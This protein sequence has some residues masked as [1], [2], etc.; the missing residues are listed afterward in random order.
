[1]AAAR[2]WLDEAAA[3]EP[4]I[5]LLRGDGGIGKS[6]LLAHLLATAREGA[7]LGLCGFCLQGARLAY[8]PL[9]SAL[10][11]LRADG[12]VLPGVP[13]SLANLFADGR[14][15][16]AG[17]SVS[18]DET[19]AAADRRHLNLVVAAAQAMLDAA[20]E[21]PLI[22]AIEDLHWADDSTLGFLELLA[23]VATQKST[24]TPV[25][26]A[27]ILTSRPTREGETAWRLTQRLKR[28]VICRD[29]E[30]TGL[31]ELEINQIVTEL[32]K[33]RPS[34]RLLHSVSEASSGNPLL[35]RSLLDR[36]IADGTIGVEKGLL[37][38]PDL[39]LPAVALDLDAELGSRLE[40]TDDR[41]AD[42]LGWAAILGDGQ[43]LTTLQTISGCD[44][45]EFDRRMGLAGSLRLLYEEGEIYRFD[46]PE[47]RE[48]L[49][50]RLPRPPA[51]PPAPGGSPVPRGRVR[52]RRPGPRCPDRLSPVAGR[53]GR[54]GNRARPPGSQRRRPLIRP[55]GLVRRRHLST[56][57]A[58]SADGSDR[59]RPCPARA[60]RRRPLP[61]PR[62]PPGRGP[63]GSGPS[64]PARAAGDEAAWGR[65]VLALTKSRV[66]GGSWLGAA[67]D[68]E[69]L[70]EFLRASSE[71]AADLRARAYSLLSDAHFAQFDFPAGFE[72]ATRA[73]EA[74]SGVD[75]HEVAAEVELAL[76][77]QHLA[78][79]HLHEAEQH[80]L[81]CQ[82]HAS[83]LADPWASSWAASRLPLVRWCQGDLA[84]AEREAT[85][86]AELA[87][88]HFDWAEAS[89]ATAC[90]VNVA[91]AQG[92]LADAE[93]LG[94]LAVQQY[95]RSDYLWT[96]LVVAPA[97]IAGRAFRG[98]AGRASEAIEMLSGAGVDTEA[99]RLA[100]AALAGQLE[101]PGAG[102]RAGPISA[103]PSPRAPYNLFDLAT[104]ALQVEVVRGHRRS[105][106]GPGRR[107]P[108]R[109]R[110]G[111]RLRASHRVGGLRA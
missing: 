110:P 17:D 82:Q 57:C 39:P 83:E 54:A 98:D 78:A 1:M 30:L 67:V 11:P 27:V 100:V 76:G 38:G 34:P 4:R 90:R 94:T 33:A 55:G 24:L 44:D 51:P 84:G 48:V 87:M 63:A 9:A 105:G 19:D 41:G 25:P 5:I 81:S 106:P 8:L 32:V 62:P 60:G 22:L 16:G 77:I 13:A 79:L 42:L 96:V 71:G 2:G 52:P 91:V 31:D 95:L 21:R 102:P 104:A 99:F 14:P 56:T 10:A 12:Q 43:S 89:L 103:A 36:L 49:Y 28:E 35:L 40:R 97:L 20:N 75:D 7:W 65:A 3:G 73:L 111:G 109:S 15:T 88:A 58:W 92:R 86:A 26:L 61:Q 37:S 70:Q 85:G 107:R 29:I 59:V 108:A 6:A 50:A 93:R 47:L 45:D 68:L 64:R 53:A 69:P 72:Q 66:T 80:L 18:G 23:A 101:A 74:A 46:H